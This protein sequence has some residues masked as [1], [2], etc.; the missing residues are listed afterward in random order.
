MASVSFGMTIVITVWKSDTPYEG[1]RQV[2]EEGE[3]FRGTAGAAGVRQLP[4]H[5]A[6]TQWDSACRDA[7][8][9][10]ELHSEES[11]APEFGTP[12]FGY[13]YITIPLDTKIENCI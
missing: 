13:V 2:A 12:G 8:R 4:S 11:S 10:A 6:D 9:R 3:S 7:K 1:D 5:W